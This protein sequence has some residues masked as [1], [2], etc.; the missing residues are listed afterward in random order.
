V[1]QHT[2]TTSN[3]SQWRTAAGTVNSNKTTKIHFTL[4]EFYENTIIEHKVHVFKTPLNYDMIIGRDLLKSLGMKLD[5]ESEQVWWREA[6]I[7]MKPV[8]ANINDFFAQDSKAMEDASER[9]KRILDAK[10]EPAD[11][12]EVATASKHLTSQEQGTLLQLLR[13][14]SDLFDG[15]L[16]NWTGTELSIDLKP[17]AEPFH[18]HSYPIPKV[19]EQTLRMEV[20]R[21]VQIGVLR[22]INHSEWGSPT[23]IIP[24]KDGS[25]RFISDFRELN[26]RIKRK[27]F[28]IPK[29]QDLMLKLEGFTYGT[30]LDLNMGYYHIKLDPNSR[31]LCT[32]V[33]PWGKYEYLRL[34]MG[35]CNSPDIFQE[36]MSELMQGLEYIR[37]YID[38]LLILSTQD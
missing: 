15:T 18:S 10:Y 38:D 35:L 23:F 8:N 2:L 4:P 7:P 9:I 5:F 26:K 1:P 30:S 14:Y 29:I 12:Q 17:G 34:P 20:D 31:K 22:K 36:K 37:V 6:F 32:I 25:V 11:L 24:K 33:L 3:S 27:P 16:G 21:L 28:P 13:K 19:H